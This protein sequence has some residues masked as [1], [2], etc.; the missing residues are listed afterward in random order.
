MFKLKAVDAEDSF[1]L[2]LAIV[3]CFFV[4][5]LLSILLQGFHVGEGYQI[6]IF[7][8]RERV[9]N[10]IVTCTVFTLM[11]F[12]SRNKDVKKTDESDLHKGGADVNQ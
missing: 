8:I 9:L 12:Y 4:S 2:A 6:G 3:S 10:I 7:F 5:F 1:Y 11:Y